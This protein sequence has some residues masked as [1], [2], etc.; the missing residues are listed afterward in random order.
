VSDTLVTLVGVP[1]VI[2]I[3]NVDE[4][5]LSI[6]WPTKPVAALLFVFVP[7]IA[8]LA[9]TVNKAQKI[10]DTYL[11]R[12][13]VLAAHAIQKLEDHRDK[14]AAKSGM[15]PPGAGAAEGTRREQK[16]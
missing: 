15:H 6:Y 12:R 10:I 3:G 8:A 9:R 13:G 11:A 14:A 7:R 4:T 2:G 1:L 5:T 16:L